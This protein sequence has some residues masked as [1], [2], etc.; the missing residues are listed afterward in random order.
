MTYHMS[1]ILCRRDVAF[2]NAVTAHQ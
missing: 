2:P 1:I